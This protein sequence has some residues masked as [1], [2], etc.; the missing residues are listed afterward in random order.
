MTAPSSRARGLRAPKRSVGCRRPATPRGLPQKQGL[1][2]PALP[3]CPASVA[4]G[5]GKGAS[6][7]RKAL[8]AGRSGSAKH[9]RRKEATAAAGRSP[10]HAGSPVPKALPASPFYETFFFAS[11]HP[12]SAVPARAPRTAGGGRGGSG[13]RGSAA[14]QRKCPRRPPP[15]LQPAPAPRPAA[16]LAGRAPRATGGGGGRCGPGCPKEPTMPGRQN[17]RDSLRVF[18]GLSLTLSGNRAGS[19]ADRGRAPRGPK[20]RAPRLVPADPGLYS[21][22]PAR[23][24]GAR[25]AAPRQARTP[26][27]QGSGRIVPAARSALVRDRQ[28]PPRAHPPGSR[29]KPGAPR[30]PSPDAAAAALRTPL[31]AGFFFPFFFFFPILMGRKVTAY[32]AFINSHHNNKNP[33]AK[34]GQ[35]AQSVARGGGRE[36]PGGGPPPGVVCGHGAGG[37]D[38]RCPRM[39]ARCP[40]PSSFS[41]S[42][43]VRRGH[44]APASGRR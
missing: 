13:A 11:P 6:G 14:G 39:P 21:P 37:A 35:Q 18:P 27:P 26:G 36:P 15:P 2:A 23:L 4:Q 24:P 31:R 42:G 41:R 43:A 8:P 5:G 10:R 19:P 1:G 17:K 32:F 3:R 16:T 7:R 33:G 34:G 44:G 28:R 25:P 40:S 29:S 12:K 20:P 9:H 22:L 38:Q 30:K